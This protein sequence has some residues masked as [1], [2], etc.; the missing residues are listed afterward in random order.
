[1]PRSARLDAPGV[2]HH[3]MGRGIEGRKFSGTKGIRGTSY[4][5]WRNFARQVLGSLCVGAPFVLSSRGGADGISGSGGGT[6]SRGNDLGG[7][8]GGLFEG[9]A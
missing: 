8:P 2:L 6:F 7:N 4:P 1:M 3:L 9:T 5:A